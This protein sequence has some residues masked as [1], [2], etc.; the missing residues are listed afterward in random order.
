MFLAKKFGSSVHAA[1]RRYAETS[2][3]RCALLVLDKVLN[4][5]CELKRRNYFQS[6]FFTRDFGNLDFPTILDIE[7]PF[8][9]DF[10]LGK[11]FHHNGLVTMITDDG[12]IDFEYH[13]FNNTFNVFIFIIPIGEKNKTRTTI[14]LKGHDD[15]A[16]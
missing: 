5:N 8:V 16:V 15:S 12:D 11:K 6:A 4:T 7:W 9:Q 13:F 3:K 10:L 14:V 2:N 1:M